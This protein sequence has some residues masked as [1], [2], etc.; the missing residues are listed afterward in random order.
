MHVGARRRGKYILPLRRKGRKNDDSGPTAG[1]SP[2]RGGTCQNEET[3]NSLI[4]RWRVIATRL[5]PVS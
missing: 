1:N 3:E 2:G 5:S 4:F